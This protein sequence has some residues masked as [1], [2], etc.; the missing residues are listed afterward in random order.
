MAWQIPLTNWKGLQEAAACRGQGKAV[1]PGSRQRVAIWPE[2]A[3]NVVGDPQT[4]LKIAVSKG[5]G[6]PVMSREGPILVILG[7]R[8]KIKSLQ[9]MATAVALAWVMGA[10][11]SH[12]VTVVTPGGVTNIT[13]GAEQ[14]N[15]AFL[16]SV[17]VAITP[18]F[19]LSGLLP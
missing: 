15:M 16:P 14:C 11:G 3:C 17:D 2:Q 10:G 18:G 19:C 9:R 13:V 1:S 6:M 12:A 8:L 5:F 4:G 7:D